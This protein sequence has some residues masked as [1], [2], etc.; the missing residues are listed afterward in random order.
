MLIKLSVFRIGDFCAEKN[1]EMNSLILMK[2]L[3][4]VALLA[5]AA[6]ATSLT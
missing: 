6:F 4:I 5:T 3:M 2:V 1:C